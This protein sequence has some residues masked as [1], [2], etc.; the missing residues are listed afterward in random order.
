MSRP[1]PL[2]FF[3]ICSVVDFVF[4]CMR[5]HSV[6]AGLGAILGGLPLTA[7]LFFVFGALSNGGE[8][9]PDASSN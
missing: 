4:G 9:P 6:Y 7:V 5:W 1:T 3:S 2:V 8:H